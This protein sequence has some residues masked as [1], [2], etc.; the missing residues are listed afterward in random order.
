MV[1]PKGN[2]ALRSYVNADYCLLERNGLYV[3]SERH[4]TAP[5]TSRPRVVGSLGNELERSG[6]K[7]SWPTRGAG[8]FLPFDS[9]GAKPPAELQ[10]CG[11]VCI[12]LYATL[13]SAQ[14]AYCGMLPYAVSSMLLNAVCYCIQYATLCSVQYAYCGMLLYAVFCMWY[15]V[16]YRMQCLVCYYIQYVTIYNMLLYAVSSMHIVVCYC[17]LCPVMLLYT[18][19]TMQYAACYRMHR[20]ICYWARYEICIM[21]YA[22]LCSAQYALCG[23][24]PYAVSSMFLYAV[25]YCIQYATLCSVQHAYCGMLLHAVSSYATVYNMHHAVSS[26]LPYAPSNMLLSTVWNMQYATA[27]IAVY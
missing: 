18:V 15:A 21:L 17:M 9:S 6:E 14:Y 25:C 2:W 11:S 20:L 22:T 19:C 24:L 1:P 13:C 8:D 23:M 3:P 10:Y 5:S 27:C 26:L 16:C 12:M 7:W 4:L